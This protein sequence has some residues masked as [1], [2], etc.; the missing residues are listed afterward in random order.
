MYVEFK[1]ENG[2]R[3]QNRLIKEF[4]EY[5]DKRLQA[6]L[7]GLGLYTLAEHRY[8]T[9]ITCLIRSP[10]ENA[11]AGGSPHSAHL[12]GRAADVRVH[13]L[14]PAQK[15]LIA[16]YLRRT[17]GDFLYVIVHGKGSN[18]H[19]HINIQYKYKER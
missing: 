4:R 6:V 2:Q 19:L 8:R 16:S 13:G 12:D 5:I 10:K 3:Y 9:V 18:E 11:K 14:T 17:W 7:L 15:S 1:T